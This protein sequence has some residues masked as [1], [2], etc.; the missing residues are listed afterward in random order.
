MTEIIP[1]LIDC[2]EKLYVLFKE[3]WLRDYKPFGLEVIALRFGG[4][5]QR[6]KDIM[7]RMEKYLA[8]GEPLYELEE[9]VLSTYYY[10]EASAFMTSSVPESVLGFTI[11]L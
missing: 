4:M 10:G 1:D 11:P 5:V 2:Y 3:M 7:E 8:G 9:K 6:L